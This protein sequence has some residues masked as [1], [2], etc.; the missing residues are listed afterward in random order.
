MIKRTN[1]NIED[2]T[3]HDLLLRI[4]ERTQ[5]LSVDLLS[6][7]DDLQNNYVDKH[8]CYPF[9]RLIEASLN[10]YITREEF[11]PVKKAVYGV[12]GAICGTVFIALIS[13][14]IK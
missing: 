13:L 8:E 2:M 1:T 7:K 9:K 4:D 12:I 5:S 10:R 11:S 14:I 6:M 3:D